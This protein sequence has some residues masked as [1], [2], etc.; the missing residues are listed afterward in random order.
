ME[1]IVLNALINYGPMTSEE[2]AI[3]TN[4]VLT[5]IT[6]RMAALHERRIVK[7][8][9][10]DDDLFITR[11]GKSGCQRLVYEFEP[12]SA[13]WL[14]KRPV[15]INRAAKIRQLEAEIEKLNSIIST[16]ERGENHGK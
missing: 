6:P 1:K 12:A 9:L 3:K 11:T 8:P 13:L 2:I 15:K 5:S 14:D 4:Q 10:D 7:R 16:Y